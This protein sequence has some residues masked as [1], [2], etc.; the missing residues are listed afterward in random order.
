MNSYLEIKDRL[1]KKDN[2]EQWDKDINTVK[3][4]YIEQITFQ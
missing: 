1:L 3:D 2:F 4:F